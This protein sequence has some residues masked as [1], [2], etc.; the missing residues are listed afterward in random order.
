MTGAK[1][2]QRRPT[3]LGTGKSP[4]ATNKS[5]AELEKSP[6][7][8]VT[9]TN[10]VST[11]SNKRTRTETSAEGGSGAKR[12]KPRQTPP[13]SHRATDTTPNPLASVAELERLIQL[14]PAVRKYVQYQ[15]N[16]NREFQDFDQPEVIVEQLSNNN[17]IWESAHDALAD[18]HNQK[19][20]C[21][22]WNEVWDEKRKMPRLPTSA[23]LQALRY[24]CTERGADLSE[25]LSTKFDEA[26]LLWFIDGG[27]PPAFW[28]GARLDDPDFRESYMA[29]GTHNKASHVDVSNLANLIQQVFSAGLQSF[30]VPS[31]VRSVAQQERGRPRRPTFDKDPAKL[32]S[33]GEGARVSTNATAVL[34]QPHQLT[35]SNQR[36]QQALTTSAAPSGARLETTDTPLSAS[37]FQIPTPRRRVFGAVPTTP[38]KGSHP[39]T[40][41]PP[42]ARTEEPAASIAPSG[43]KEGWP[44]MM[45]RLVQTEEP[46]SSKEAC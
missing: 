42:T 15:W 14:N 11:V 6:P 27:S 10:N 35:V 21:K 17:Q 8:V 7:S 1:V 25:L 46:L 22:Q 16:V 9:R 41:T 29:A 38:S 20:D 36:Q 3:S 31:V 32:D 19:G 37:H 34:R 13:P 5:Q 24:T 40:P 45:A 26:E 18:I 44:P 43:R 2:P 12:Q 30:G 33:E 39:L 23:Q 4:I 28:L